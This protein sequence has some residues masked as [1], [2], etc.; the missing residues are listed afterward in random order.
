MSSKFHFKND[1][2]LTQ[3]V[4]KRPALYIVWPRR[5]IFSQDTSLLVNTDVRC[6]SSA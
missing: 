4:Q 1:S 2:N 6:V 5:Y 3:A